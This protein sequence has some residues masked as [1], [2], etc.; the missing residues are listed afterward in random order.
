[1]V[2]ILLYDV[3]FSSIIIRC[4]LHTLDVSVCVN[5]QAAV[6]AVAVA[7]AAAAAARVLRGC[8]LVTAVCSCD[9]P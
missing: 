2:Y 7:V 5:V 6:A 8:C 4:A 9:H 1:L 3:R